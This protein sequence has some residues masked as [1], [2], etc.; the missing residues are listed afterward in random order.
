VLPVP[1][2]PH[3]GGVVLDQRAAPG[4]GTTGCSVGNPRHVMYASAFLVSLFL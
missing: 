3:L 4:F 1:V 2:L